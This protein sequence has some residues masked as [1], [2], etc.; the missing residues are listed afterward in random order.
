MC[1]TLTADCC[2]L[3]AVPRASTER[4][5][6][7]ISLMTPHEAAE[8][9]M[10]YHP[11][12]R[13]TRA[14]SVWLFQLHHGSQHPRRIRDDVLLPAGPRDRHLGFHQVQEGGQE[15]PGG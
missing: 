7:C 8:R 10:L 9:D 3:C 13:H 11:A 12:A 2:V 6:V 4:F 15:G 14:P 1:V 5:S